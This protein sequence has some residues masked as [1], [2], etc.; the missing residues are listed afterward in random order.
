MVEQYMAIRYVPA[1]GRSR[2]CRDSPRATSDDLLARVAL[3]DADGLA[4]YGV[5][6]DVHQ[7]ESTLSSQVHIVWLTLPQNVQV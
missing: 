4:L 6:H 1:N 3:P 2:R 5:L 7:S